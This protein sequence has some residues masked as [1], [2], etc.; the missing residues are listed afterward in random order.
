MMQVIVT[1][2]WKQPKCSAIGELLASHDLLISVDTI[3]T[4]G[5]GAKLDK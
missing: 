5:L 3:K 2:H 4:G 1:K